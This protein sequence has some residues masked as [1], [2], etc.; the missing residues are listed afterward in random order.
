MLHCY[1][2]FSGLWSP[3]RPNILN[4][5]KYAFGTEYTTALGVDVVEWFYTSVN[6]VAKHSRSI[7]LFIYVQPLPNAP[8]E[9][10]Y[11]ILFESFQGSDNRSSAEAAVSEQA[12][13]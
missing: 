13:E 11:C 7:F 5:P 9:W 6:M 1:P 12:S 8:S 3:V 4:I 10:M 2:T